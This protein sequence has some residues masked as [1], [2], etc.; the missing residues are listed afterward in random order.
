MDLTGT[1]KIINTLKCCEN[2]ELQ[3]LSVDI[4]FTQDDSER[5][6]GEKM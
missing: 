5:G 2:R 1:E 6:G 4:G 3:Q